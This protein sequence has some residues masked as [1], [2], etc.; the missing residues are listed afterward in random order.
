MQNQNRTHGRAIRGQRVYGL[1]Q[2]KRSPRIN[3]VAGYCDGE[4]LGDLCFRG[5]MNA[6]RFEDWFSTHLLP[7]LKPDDVVILDNASHHRKK[8]LIRL[9]KS[10]GVIVLFLPTYSPDFNKIEKVWAN[11]KRFLRNYSD[12]RTAIINW[13][14]LYF[15]YG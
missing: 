4:I 11:L 9:A 3:V 12:Q 10:C 8:H 13:I 2:G 6:E 7:L 15:D 5:S 14:Y 1:T